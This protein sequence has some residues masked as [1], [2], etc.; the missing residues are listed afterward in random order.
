MNKYMPVNS[1]A[2][3]GYITCVVGMMKLGNTMPMV[4]VE[5][6]CLAF[7][8]SI[9]PL[10]HIGSLMTPLYPCPPVCAASCLK[11]QCRLLYSSPWI[12]S[13]L[14]LTITKIQAM[15]I[16]IHTQGRFNNHVV[17]SL[18]RMLVM[19]TR[20]LH[21]YRRRLSLSPSLSHENG[22]DIGSY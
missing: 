5:P 8:A 20:P 17:R 7:Q 22:L 2:N 19:E 14:M 3:V 16:H 21:M 11:S 6:T 9:P 12:V 13:L 10:H 15:A 1:T 4:G 18:C